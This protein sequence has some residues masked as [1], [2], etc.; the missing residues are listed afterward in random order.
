[1]LFAIACS[2]QPAITATPRTTIFLAASNN[3][4]SLTLDSAAALFKCRGPNDDALMNSR[5]ANLQIARCRVSKST[6]DGAG[7][8]LFATR[9]IFP[10]EL[11]TFYP[12]D[13]M[14]AWSTDSDGATSDLTFTV[15]DDSNDA[16]AECWRKLDPKWLQGAWEYGVMVGMQRASLGDPSNLH[17]TAYSRTWRTTPQCA[18][19][20]AWRLSV[21]RP[22]RRQPPMST[23]TLGL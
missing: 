5:V 20:R 6:I 2:R 19:G 3:D 10:G 4:D 13:T 18:L 21:T 9:E 1:M 11:V 8:G 7:L 17:D 14:A 15:A 22:R 12:C 16:W 23:S